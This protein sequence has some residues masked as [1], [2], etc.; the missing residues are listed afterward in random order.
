MR[1]WRWRSCR[2]LYVCVRAVQGDLFGVLALDPPRRFVGRCEEA[3]R[4]RFAKWVEK[5]GAGASQGGVVSW[6]TRHP[7]LWRICQFEHSG[8]FFPLRVSTSGPPSRRGRGLE[9]RS[10][11]IPWRA[12]DPSCG[13]SLHRSPRFCTLATP[14]ASAPAAARLEMDDTQPLV[15][16]AEA[17]PSLNESAV[18]AASSGVASGP[19]RFSASALAEWR[20]FLVAY[21]R[22]DFP[23]GVPPPIP[24]AISLLLASPAASDNSAAPPWLKNAW[25]RPET[26]EECEWEHHRRR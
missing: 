14:I 23:R 16:A 22:G 26:P 13:F 3:R 21:E 1:M 7:I 10:L 15:S 18:A 19:L 8:S 20:D 5:E 9:G 25:A 6:H 4:S 11:S 2:W 24:S 17:A 12:T